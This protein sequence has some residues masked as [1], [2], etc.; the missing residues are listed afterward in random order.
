MI[1]V[2]LNVDS[3]SDTTMRINRLHSPWGVVRPA[4]TVA[5]VKESKVINEPG[6]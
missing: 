5:P 1:D 4:H 6:H 3:I 2:A